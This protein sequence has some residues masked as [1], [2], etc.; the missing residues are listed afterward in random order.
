MILHRSVSIKELQILL[1]EGVIKGNYNITNERQSTASCNQAVVSAFV[2]DVWWIDKRHEILLLL[3]IP[4]ARL[5]FGI[6][7]YWASA[8]FDKTHIWSGRR[9]DNHYYIKEAYFQYYTIHEVM[10]VGIEF[11]DE[12][13]HLYNMLK[14]YDKNIVSKDWLIKQTKNKAINTNLKVN[15]A[16]K[17]KAPKISLGLT[18]SLILAEIKNYIKGAY[19]KG[20][21]L[22]VYVNIGDKKHIIYMDG[23]RLPDYK[24]IQSVNIITISRLNGNELCKKQFDVNENIVQTVNDYVYK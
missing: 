9:G 20:N 17:N 1:N 13:K 19:E 22:H 8:N 23:R 24:Y 12:Y 18:S 14:T 4:E 7:D 5:T 16:N 3:D 21:K 6:G 11:T 15:P 2:G 10:T